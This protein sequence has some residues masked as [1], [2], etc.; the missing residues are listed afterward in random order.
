MKF[1]RMLGLVMVVACGLARAQTFPFEDDFSSYSPGSTGAPVWSVLAGGMFNASE[2]GLKGSVLVR[3]NIRPPRSYVAEMT[4]ALPAGAPPE[5]TLAAFRFNGQDEKSM[6]SA[7][8]AA[9]QT[10]GGADSATVVTSADRRVTSTASLAIPKD[11]VVS[12][13]LAVDGDTGRYAI[14]SGDTL[15]SKGASEYSAGLL[16]LELGE[17]S[18]LRHFALRVVTEEEKKALQVTT[19]FND[20]RDIADGGDGL[21]LVLHRGSPAMFA[22]TPDGEVI[23]SFG[24][25]I[26]TAL[27]DPVAMAIGISKEVLVLNRYPGEVIA[28]DRNGGLRRRFGR[29]NLSRPVDMTVLASGN[30][31]VADAGAHAIAVF[32]ADG[33]YLG[34]CKLGTDE[35]SAIASDAAGNLLVSVLPARTIAFRPATQPSNLVIVRE[36]PGGFEAQIAVGHS[37]WAFSG[38]AIT[39]TGGAG[40]FTAAAVGALGTHGRMASVNGTVYVLDRDHSRF[41]A[42]PPALNDAAPEVTLQNA[43]GSSALVRWDAMTPVKTARVHLLRG[44]TWDT[45]RQDTAKPA[46]HLQVLLE[47]LKPGMKYKYCVSPTLSTVPPSDW[48]GEYTFTTPASEAKP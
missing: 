37:T 13:R 43:A 4:V 29:G 42:V 18:T 25:R 15:L 27:V 32:G 23:R 46:A 10:T 44:S 39:E 33:K 14:W 22:V 19:L 24:R 5:G 31:Y 35:P 9:L 8:V 40:R 48:S 21:I 16:A 11:G 2:G 30:V 36:A 47:R 6:Q 3:Y 12:L 34:A 20:P 1:A 26:A 38:G 17:N 41:V 7:D 45:L 28:Y